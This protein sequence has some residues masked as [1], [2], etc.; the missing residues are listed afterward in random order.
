LTRQA[1]E[2]AGSYPI[3]QGTLA[4]S[5]NY[6]LS[7]VGDNL[8]IAPRAITV[9]ADPQNKVYG[10]TDSALTYHLGTLVGTDT[11]TG[12]L[13][14]QAGEDAGSYDIQQ[15]TL[16]ATANY[17]LSF[18]GAQL[19]I[20]PAS[21]TTALTSSQNPSSQG[22]SVTLTATVSPVSPATA[23]PIGNVQFFVNDAAAGDPVPLSGAVALLTTTNL[24][25]LTNTVTAVFVGN[26]NF[27]SSTGSVSQVV[28]GTVATPTVIGAVLNSDGTITLTFQGSSGAQY[29]V[30]AMECLSPLSCQN[31]STNTADSA[32]RWTLTTPRAGYNQRFFRPAKP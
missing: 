8:G 21:T 5:A 12:S 10:A 1:G 3:Q 11:L 13:T 9:T 23:T 31:I 2:D 30:Q 27:L 22:S 14:R 16:A 32:G 17:T 6:T 29:V 15:G 24:P 26:G 4:A 19:T 18:M 28:S 7:F 25:P 20:S